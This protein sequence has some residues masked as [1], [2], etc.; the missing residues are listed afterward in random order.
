MSFGKIT[1]DK[2][3]II[4]SKYIRLRD[5]FKCVRCQRFYRDG[6]GLQNSHFFGRGME[7]TRFDVQNC[8]SLCPGCHQFWGSVD[9]ESYRVFKIK[10]L[11]QRGFDLLTLRAKTPTKKDR[12]IM[13]LLWTQEYKKLLTEK[14]KTHS[15]FI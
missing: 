6:N 7:S 9:R 12:K 1:L 15:K 11:G 8:D 3:D 2:A 13:Y 14:K 5:D 4:F 10:Q